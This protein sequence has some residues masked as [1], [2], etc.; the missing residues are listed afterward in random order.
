MSTS[1][2]SSRR[3]SGFALVDAIIAG[4]VLAIGLTMI[5]MLTSRSL[6]LQRRGEIEVMAAGM[7]DNI[8][9]MVLLEGPADYP[10]LHPVSGQGEF[11]Y[12][13]FEYRVNIQDPGEG[14]PYSVSVEVTH[15]TGRSYRCETLIAAKLGEEPDPVRYPEEPI[16]REARYEEIYGF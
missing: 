4:V 14:E 16:D 10:D 5:F 7:M 2:G 6:D 12:E 3:R 15:L 1:M 11:P 9:S 13:Q 8:L